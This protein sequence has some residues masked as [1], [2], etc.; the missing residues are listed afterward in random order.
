ML[1]R[2]GPA[3]DRP[4]NIAKEEGSLAHGTAW[5]LS[6][7]SAKLGCQTIY[8]V[9]IARVLGVDSFGALAATIALVS[10][11][12]PF[13]AWGA[14]NILV[15]EVSREPTSFSASYGNALVTVLLSGLVLIP[16][17]VLVGALILPRVPIAALVALTIAD[18]AF[19]RVAELA[20]PAFQAVNRL[21]ATA[22][23]TVF[24]PAARC[25]AA[26]V[27]AVRLSE[28]DLVAWTYY[29]LA[30]TIVA[31]AIS[32]WYVHRELGSP[33]VRLRDL[34]G[35]LKIGGYFAVSASASTIYADIDK[36]MLGR[37]STFDATGIYAAADRAVGMA[38]MPVMALLTAAYPRFF[39]AGVDGIRGSAAYARRLVPVSV[40]YGTA[41]GV[42]IFVLA[43]LAPYVLGSDF[44]ASIGALRWL[45]PMPLLSALYYLPGDAL[46]GADAQGLR[47][48]LQ[49]AAAALNVLLNLFLIPA[50][51]WRGAAW[52][53]LVSVSFLAAALWIATLL[54]ERRERT[55]PAADGST[56]P[57]V[58]PLRRIG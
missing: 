12:V 55:L 57:G 39:R 5:I 26:V 20:A 43:P 15:M 53:T 21:A 41:A 31:A 49:L 25:V 45:A 2:R 1:R 46:T 56:P 22:T 42:G 14:A 58:P 17:T 8:F 35:N 18:L 32:A 52:S 48:L 27:F 23:T 10:M 40:A 19:G 13:A 28:D 6:A 30:G 36:T 24:L 50:Y 44:E 33:T 4:K 47:T 29:Y 11:V 3:P 51:S 37:L 16:L 54:L 38:F 9:L 34:R 7:Q